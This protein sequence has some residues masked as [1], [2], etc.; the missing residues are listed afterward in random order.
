MG[1]ASSVS[2]L[3]SIDIYSPPGTSVKLGSE[4]TK[5]DILKGSVHPFRRDRNTSVLA[6][7]AP[8]YGFTVKEAADFLGYD[9]FNWLNIVTEH[10]FIGDF[11]YN[12]TLPLVDPPEFFSDGTRYPVGP[13]VFA[14]SKPFYFNEREL[15]PT[16]SASAWQS[17][18]TPNGGDA[19]VFNDQP[20]DFRLDRSIGQRIS[21]ATMLVGV[22]KDGK[23]DYLL[24]PFYW[25]T[26]FTGKVGGT[27]IQLFSTPV[28]YGELTGPGG[29]SEIAFY[30][31]LSDMPPDLVQIL[32][33]LGGEFAFVPE[34]SSAGFMFVF[35][36][37][38]LRR[39]RRTVS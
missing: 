10:P 32:T 5:N 13:G 22:R 7:F 1:G 29:V 3:G 18:I 9:H 28:D 14:D 8:K 19:F 2:A 16:Y 4:I 23:F 25:H 31:G 37:P 21:F 6:Y 17:W 34:P 35:L 20:K 12:T 33:E 30:Q 38:L 26:D 11:P 39:T 24:P 27:E 36:F 15:G